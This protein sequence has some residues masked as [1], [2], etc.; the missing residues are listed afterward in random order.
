MQEL[1]LGVPLAPVSS[2]LYTFSLLVFRTLPKP[3]KEKS[4]LVSRV[5]QQAPPYW[6]SEMQLLFILTSINYMAPILTYDMP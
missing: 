6:V 2:L 4:D 1:G 3:H 5:L